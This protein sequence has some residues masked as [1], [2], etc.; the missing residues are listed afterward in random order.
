MWL[1]VLGC[2]STSARTTKLRRAATGAEGARKLLMEDGRTMRLWTAKGLV[3]NAEVCMLNEVD[4]G[5]EGNDQG[6][7]VAKGI[8]GISLSEIYLYCE[9]GAHCKIQ[10]PIGCPCFRIQGVQSAHA[11]IRW[12]QKVTCS[13]RTRRLTCPQAVPAADVELNLRCLRSL[14]FTNTV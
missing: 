4:R 1:A 3:I 5:S 11:K 8:L 7:W 2:E 14:F 9:V 10:L 13:P 12:H 6:G